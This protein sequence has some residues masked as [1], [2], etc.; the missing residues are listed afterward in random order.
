MTRSFQP[1]AKH[2]EICVLLDAYGSLLTERQLTFIRHYY[3]Q[4]LTFGEIADEYHV[5]RQAVYAAVKHGIA[6]LE[7]FEET[8]GLVR[9]GWSA[10]KS[11]NQTPQNISG[12]LKKIC[13]RIDHHNGLDSMKMISRELKVVVR[14]LEPDIRPD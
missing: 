2:Y 11:V 12:R 5:T 13:E 9:G 14:M 6:S 8:L 7:Q 4:D 10:W 3:E 1:E